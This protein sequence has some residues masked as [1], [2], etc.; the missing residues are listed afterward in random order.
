MGATTGRGVSPPLVVPLLLTGAGLAR[1]T[2]LELGSGGKVAGFTAL[3]RRGFGRLQ[4]LQTAGR[5]ATRQAVG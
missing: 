1:T 4:E 3:R 5:A 2:C